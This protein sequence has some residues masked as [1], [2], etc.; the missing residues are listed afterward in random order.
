MEI[1]C[2]SLFSRRALR[3]SGITHIGEYMK[4][5]G[6]FTAAVAAGIKYP[7][8]LDLGLIFSSKPAVTAGVFTKNQVIAPPLVLDMER[9]KQGRAQA[10]LVNS[11]CANACTGEQG[12]ESCIRTGRMVAEGLSIPEDMVLLSSTGVIGEQLKME[13]FSAAVPTLIDKL[14]PENFDD[15]ARAIMTTDTVKKNGLLH[16]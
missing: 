12:M 13:A 14:S 3:K 8:R 2:S 4:I 5:D 1:R 11:G 16:C 15:V 10:I 6:F 9:L 7:D